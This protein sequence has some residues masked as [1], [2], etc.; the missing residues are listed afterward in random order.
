MKNV[1]VC[2]TSY[3]FNVGGVPG[4]YIRMFEWAEKNHYDSVLLLRAD[5]K[6]DESWT[7]Q[8]SRLNVHIKYYSFTLFSNVKIA[9]SMDS[10]TWSNDQKI[11]IITSDIHCYIRMLAMQKEQGLV[12][13]Y[14]A[15]YI[16]HPNASRVMENKIVN[17]PYA[18]LLKEN[19]GETIIFM[20]RETIYSCRKF[21]RVCIGYDEYFRLGVQIQGIEEDF[22]KQKA[23][24]KNKQLHVLAVARMDFPFK[25]YL[26]GLL[27]SFAEVSARYPDVKLTVIGS[28]KDELAFY[29]KLNTLNASV[30]EKIT[31][32]KN[33]PYSELD[34]FFKDA[35][36]FVGM[37]TTLLDAANCAVPS[38]VAA[39]FQCEAESPGFFHK[40]YDNV[41]GNRLFCEKMYSFDELIKNCICCSNEQYYDICLQSYH[42]LKQFYDINRVMPEI[43]AHMEKTENPGIGRCLYIYDYFLTGAKTILQALLRK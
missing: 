1:L 43:L 41:G 7:K 8:L 10:Y 3:D 6:I 17:F 38:V 32:I 4:Y 34:R 23:A 36:L 22:L 35:H 42:T 21:Y 14:T 39:A 13:C 11:N 33:V 24:E 19:F 16:L 28:G 5:R 29:E 40:E 15:L 31:C 9:K 18:K 2:A 20:D 30:R 27:D 25:G 37:G 12:N 26:L